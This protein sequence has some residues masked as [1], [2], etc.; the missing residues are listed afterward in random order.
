M[1]AVNTTAG[2][3]ERAGVK[4]RVKYEQGPE[5]TRTYTNTHED[6]L[7]TNDMG[8]VSLRLPDRRTPVETTLGWMTSSSA[9]SA[10][11]GL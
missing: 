10:P 2:N 6:E 7:V 5:G 9:N 8:Q 4:F 3:V 11:T 1:I